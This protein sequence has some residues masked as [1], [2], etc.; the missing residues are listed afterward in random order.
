M[1]KYTISL[2][3]SVQMWGD[4]MPKKKKEERGERLNLL[5]TP[6]LTKKLNSYCLKVANK[7]GKMPHGIKT[8]IGRKA[9]EE[10]LE[11]HGDDTA[12]KF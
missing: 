2:F 8:T 3:L 4:E 7:L 6:E 10:W 12:T 11:K 9:I 5:L 1:L